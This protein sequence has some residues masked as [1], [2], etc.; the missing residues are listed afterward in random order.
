[1]CEQEQLASDL[2]R[3]LSLSQLSSL[4]ASRKLA[5]GAKLDKLKGKS[6]D[7]RAKERAVHSASKGGKH[8]MAAKA[9]TSETIQKVKGQ[10]KTAMFSP[11]R[12]ELSSCSN[13][14]YSDNNVVQALSAD[15]IIYLSVSSIHSQRWLR[16]LATGSSRVSGVSWKVVVGVSNKSLSLS[17]QT[18]YSFVIRRP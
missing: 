15:S 17:S 7:S 14:E 3:A 12:S 1:M 2:D 11:V 13:S 10:K 5:S 6:A 4:N 8:K 16:Q 9:S 18:S